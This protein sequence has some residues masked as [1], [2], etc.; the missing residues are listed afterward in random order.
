[1]PQ[2]TWSF[3]THEAIMH[4]DGVQV[5]SQDLWPADP[6]RGKQSPVLARF[7]VGGNMTVAKIR[8]VWWELVKKPVSTTAAPVVKIPGQKVCSASTST[9][10]AS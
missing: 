1:M 6:K 4:V 2:C 7:V 5:R 9:L 3:P 10:F 8:S